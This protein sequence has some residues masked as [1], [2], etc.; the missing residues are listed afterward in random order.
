M[1][2]A[3]LDS[4][5]R[6]RIS[7][8][9]N[10]EQGLAVTNFLRYDP[11]KAFGVGQPE[12]VGRMILAF[13]APV[14]DDTLRCQPWMGEPPADF[15]HRPPLHTDAIYELQRIGGL[16]CTGTFPI[17]TMYLGSR[18][19]ATGMRPTFLGL[20]IDDRQTRARLDA[21]AVATQPGGVLDDHVICARF[22][23]LNNLTVRIEQGNIHELPPATLSE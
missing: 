4:L 22:S 9:S 23:A 3:D 12:R 7:L 15:K 2:R 11:K 6:F 1:A 10:Y 18:D 16:A 21:V 20:D 5:Y 14:R 8:S 17:W 19:R 13:D